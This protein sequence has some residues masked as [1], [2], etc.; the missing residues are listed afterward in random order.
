M[1]CTVCKSERKRRCCVI[2]Q[3]GNVSRYNSGVFSLAPFV[4]PF[5]APSYHAQHLRSLHFAAASGCRVLWVTAYD[6][7]IKTD[8]QLRPEQEEA[9][10]ERWLEYHE[11]ATSGIPGLLPL[12]LDLPIRFTDAP[13]GK[14]REQGIFKHTRGILR[15]WDLPQAE[16]T[17]IAS[18]DADTR[19]IVLKLRPECL[20]IE[21][22]SATAK[23]ATTNGKKLF[24]LPMTVK[25]WTLDRQGNVRVRRH[26]FPIVPDFGGTAHAYCGDTL[27]AV[28]GDLLKWNHPPNL[29]NAERAY[30]IKSR[31]RNADN[32]L[33]AQPYC[34]Q[35]F[36]QGVQPGPHLLLRVLQQ[37]LTPKEA[38][39]EWKKVEAKEKA[40]QA[41]NKKNWMHKIEIPCR[42]CTDK[43]AGVEIRRPISLFTVLPKDKPGEIWSE[44]MSQ[45]QDA[46]CLRC[47]FALF[48]EGGKRDKVVNAVGCERCQEMRPP[49]MFSPEAVLAWTGAAASEEPILCKPC[50]GI[51]CTTTATTVEMIKCHGY[52]CNR[53]VPVYFFLERHLLDWRKKGSVEQEALCCR[54]HMAVNDA[55]TGE[56]LVVCKNCEQQKPIKEFTA[57]AIKSFYANYRK[58]G[59]HW[60]CQDCHFPACVFCAKIPLHSIVHNSL[61]SKAEYYGALKKHNLQPHA[62]AAEAFASDRDVYICYECKYPP[63]QV[64]GCSNTREPHHKRRYLPWTCTECESKKH[65]PVKK[66]SKTC[67]RW[68]RSEEHRSVQLQ[69]YKGV[70]CKPIVMKRPSSA[71]AS[72]AAVLRKRPSHATPQT[73][74]DVAALETDLLDRVAHYGF[75]EAPVPP[76]V[77]RN[78]ATFRA[79]LLQHGT[80]PTGDVALDSWVKDMRSAFDKEEL[81]VETMNVLG[82]VPE[83]SWKAPP[84]P[85]L[86]I[87]S[88]AVDLLVRCSEKDVHFSLEDLPEEMLGNASNFREHHRQ[89]KGRDPPQ[90]TTLG[91]WIDNM[92]QW[93]HTK[94]MNQATETL[95]SVIPEWHW[96]AQT[97][98]HLFEKFKANAEAFRTY[99]RDHGGKD[100][101][102]SEPLGIW[103]H[104]TR[105]KLMNNTL[106]PAEHE[107]L[108][109]IK[110]W[111]WEAQ[112][113]DE[114]SEQFKANAEAFRKYHRDNG[115]KDPVQSDPLGRWVNQTRHRWKKQTLKQAEHEYLTSIKEWRW[116]ARKSHNE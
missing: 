111:H 14:A 66:R 93:H 86:F 19:Q 35:L 39:D 42:G 22:P 74:K 37:D 50:L 55:A 6:K 97:A 82:L 15:G 70:S 73:L 58:A 71:A 113:T 27:P 13:R 38:K 16:A 68:D 21:V 104:N 1:E 76:A 108:T 80:D 107:Y 62:A 109:S 106:K 102:Q 98:D 5:R 63:C 59:S 94:K 114:V 116:E 25:T 52:S 79:Y 105:N 69:S 10:R 87:N 44:V 92:R 30:I 47:K 115:G 45:G 67:L 18:I 61:V 57:V 51:K 29:E 89:M 20:Y 8:R 60:V 103:V 49:E 110:E 3:G 34:P 11:R 81:D 24:K 77:L 43:N 12:I 101:K 83:W 95:L 96:E 65:S 78:A 84:E 9:R 85:E 41:E 23:L 28:I 99:H 90:K 48:P 36:H 2:T 112:T 31:I 7:M 88:I 91:K 53:P 46:C 32:L 26:G 40:T 100:P 33:L 64:S 75:H 54:C 56:K 4:H 72:R 17:R